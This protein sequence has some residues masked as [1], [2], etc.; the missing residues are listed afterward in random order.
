M[1]LSTKNL[2]HG[3]KQGSYFLALSSTFV[4]LLIK[5]GMITKKKLAKKCG[6]IR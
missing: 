5:T 1:I 2:E 4:L 6:S 3:L